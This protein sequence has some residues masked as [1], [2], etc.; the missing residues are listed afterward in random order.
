V[1][2]AEGSDAAAWFDDT[3]DGPVTAKVSI[4]GKSVPVDGAWVVI[5]PPNYAPGLVG[6]RTLYEAPM[7]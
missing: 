1:R 7:V 5:A 6:W 3:S 4:D 2:V